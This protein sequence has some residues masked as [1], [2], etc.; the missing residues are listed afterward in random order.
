MGEDILFETAKYL[1]KRVDGF[2]IYPNLENV[3]C[4]SVIN[5]ETG[6]TEF[7]DLEYPRCIHMCKH[8][9]KQLAAELETDNTTQL[10][11]V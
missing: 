2:S 7:Q 8:L 3:P 9:D 11:L 4:Y 1:V 5:K 10:S 6:V